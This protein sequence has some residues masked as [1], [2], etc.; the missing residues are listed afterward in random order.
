MY[1]S[2]G[3]K[4]SMW[5][6]A[7]ISTRDGSRRQNVSQ[8][9]GSANGVASV[10]DNPA[11]AS[12]NGP[13]CKVH[14]HLLLWFLI[15]SRICSR[16]SCPYT[17][18]DTH[19]ILFLNRIPSG[20]LDKVL[21]VFQNFL[22]CFILFCEVARPLHGGMTWIS[23]VNSKSFL[24]YFRDQGVILCCMSH[25][26]TSWLFSIH[27]QQSV[28][29]Q[30]P[31]WKLLQPP[32]CFRHTCVLRYGWNV[33]DSENMRMWGNFCPLKRKWHQ[34]R[35]CADTLHKPHHFTW[36]MMWIWSDWHKREGLIILIA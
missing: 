17:R 29:R 15:C 20:T 28:C 6:T 16:L 30:G 11:R 34:Q 32:L 24:F 18:S 36:F 10:K 8:C 1:C 7:G 33:W 3:I 25:T 27:T 9:H 19:Q 35:F 5:V 22:Y 13:S 31:G 12:G 21:S 23:A 4:Y 26:A 2:G 14:K